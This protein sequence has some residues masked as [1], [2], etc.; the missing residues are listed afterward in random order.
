MKALK[1]VIL[2]TVSL[3]GASW[4]LPGLLGLRGLYRIVDARG[5]TPSTYSTSLFF[6]YQRA[7][8]SHEITFAPP[9]NPD[10]DTVIVIN[11][12]EHY[13]D[14]Q[15][16][17]GFG[18]YENIEAAITIAGQAA[19]WL[20]DQSF[21]RGDYVGTLDAVWDFT[22]LT[23]SGK[24]SRVLRED[25][26]YGGAL[27]LAIPLAPALPDTAA[28][29]DGF[30]Q[31]DEIM[32]QT[33][34]PYVGRGGFAGGLLGLFTWETPYVEA[35]GNLGFAFLNQEVEDPILGTLRQSD[36][37]ID[38]GAGVQ[39]DVGIVDFFAEIA[40]RAFLSRGSDPAYEM[41]AWAVVGMRVR[42]ESGTFLD[43]GVQIGLTGHNR[44]ARDVYGG[45]PIEVP[46]GVPCEIGFMLNMGWD[47]G[48][49]PG[50][51]SSGGIIAGVVTDASSGAPL[52]ATISLGGGGS[53]RSDSLTGFYS[54]QARPGICVV[55]AG[56]DG[57]RPV[58]S[59][60]V[61]E[62]GRS[63]ALDFRLQ[64]AGPPT[65]TVTGM[66]F[67]SETGAPISAQVTAE[68]A[69][70]TVSADSDGR[71]VMDL[72]QG[73]WTLSVQSQGH[74]RGTVQVQIA[75]GGST[76]TSV[77]LTR[78]LETGQVMSFAN[79]H[80]DSGSANLKTDSY[81][82]LDGVADLLMANQTARVEIS[83]HTDSD[84]SESSNQQLS[85][86]RAAAVRDYLVRRGVPTAML[87]TVGY[88]EARPVASNS[89]ADGKAQ[90]R[91]IEFRVL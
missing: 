4:A 75:A 41:P 40:A 55:T 45:D 3:T 17:I 14:A 69:G 6:T 28:D 54:I 88:G 38:A 8:V 21:P 57:Y 80:F 53:V 30:W 5:V 50:G 35:M 25:M 19:V 63:A 58:S 71:F 44:F 43:L 12:S 74:G 60:V 22:D 72:P 82:I 52:G 42:E 59:T 27:W 39:R 20:Y 79:I 86:R 1:T 83:G 85:E 36:T 90:N 2:L 24:Y 46:G 49:G 62:E 64:A 67:D 33:R 77:T 56:A 11:D 16:Q 81:T 51:P 91:R 84:G 89:T 70:V 87:T 73:T 48:T 34:R 18:I 10:I 32:H 26:T 31:D 47:P 7:N 66:V 78:A 23:V 29:Y 13:G 15:L 65:G 61:L 37:A 76:S 9:I 68:G